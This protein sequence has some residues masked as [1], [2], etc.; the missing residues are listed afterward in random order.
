MANNKKRVPNFAIPDTSDRGSTSAGPFGNFSFRFVTGKHAA[1]SV[2]S[3]SDS[4]VPGESHQF[5]VY[6]YG[7]YSHPDYDSDTS[8]VVLPLNGM[9]QQRVSLDKNSKRQPFILT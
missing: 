3:S 5:P 7:R 8:S 2:N 1:V 4:S 6:P 9:Y